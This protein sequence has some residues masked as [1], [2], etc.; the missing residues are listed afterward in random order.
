M[1][2]LSQ[3]VQQLDE[4]ATLRMAQLARNLSQQGKPVI[5]LTLGE[6]DFDTPDFIKDAA[7]AALKA[8]HT[9]YTPVA[10]TQNLREA[11]C[12]KLQ[13]ENAL[14]FRPE[15][16]VVSNGAKQSFANLCQALLDPED[17]V[18]LVA[19]YWVS[20]KEIA[21]LAE[22]RTVLISA[23]VSRN[24]KI[25]AADLAAALQAQPKAR[26]LVFSSPCN[27]TGAVFTSEE[28]R[29][30]AEILR[31]YPD[32]IV[33]SD[34]IYEYINFTSEGHVSLLNVLGEGD[35]DL[36]RRTVIINGFS[37][38]YAMTGWRL[39]YIAA[40][41]VIAD[42]CIKI[43]GQ[44]TSGANA[45][46]QQAAITALQG[47]KAATQYMTEKFKE[48][49]ALI[50]SLLAPIKGLQCNQ[51][52]GAFYV[53]PDISSLLGKS[54]EGEKIQTAEDFAMLLLT[55]AH[56][57]TVSGEGFGAPRCLRLSYATSEENLRQAAQR[58]A[59]FVDKLT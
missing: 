47:G 50:L 42:A 43:Q 55:K 51:P 11:I 23:D 18:L 41:K 33:V 2:K 38:G 15:N 58:I 53:F 4:S 30:W 22:A 24:Y 39:G 37:K 12:S 56:V 35:A 31:Q 16:I 1:I 45:F 25:S 6:P 44:C 14:T 8:G 7:Y 48:R 57:A 10:G 20:Y 17:V 29:Q 27:P 5:S 3:R 28:L 40:D 26:M 21:E 19:P 49:R 52:E 9:K 59:Q 32:L 36:R 54:Y 13:Q 46:A 34:E